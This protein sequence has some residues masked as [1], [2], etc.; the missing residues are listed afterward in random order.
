MDS[1]NSVY[2]VTLNSH[3]EAL[4]HCTMSKRLQIA[5]STSQSIIYF[6]VNPHCYLG[7]PNLKYQHWS[8]ELTHLCL[9]FDNNLVALPF[10]SARVVHVPSHHLLRETIYPH[11]PP[12]VNQS[13]RLFDCKHPLLLRVATL[14]ELL[15]VTKCVRRQPSH[16]WSRGGVR[17]RSVTLWLG[18]ARGVSAYELRLWDTSFRHIWRW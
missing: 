8:Y 13:P 7:V 10:P 14:K 2:E 3:S 11:L 16:C 12:G 4:S 5:H 17:V 15:L 1:S 18:S 6:T 9:H